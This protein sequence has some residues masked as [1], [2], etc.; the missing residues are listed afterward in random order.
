[1]ITDGGALQGDLQYKLGDEG[2]WTNEVPTAK[3][4]GTYKVYYKLE[5]ADKEAGSVEVTVSPKPATLSLNNQT[6]YVGEDLKELTFTVEGRAEGD[7][8]G[9]VTPK[10]DADKATVG[11][12]VISADLTDPNPNY[13][14]TI[15]TGI[16][17]IKEPEPEPQPEPEPKP[18]PS[19]EVS[20]I[21]LARMVSKGTNKLT[22]SWPKVQNVDGYEIRLK[23]CGAKKIQFVKTIKG[24][25]TFTYTVKGR[26]KKKTYVAYV[27][28]FVNKN[29]KKNFVK[30]SPAVHAFTTKGNKKYTN[31]K[32]VKVNK[33]T[34]T[35][36]KGKSTTIKASVTRINKRRKLINTSHGPTLRYYST[37]TKIA[38]VDNKGKI[39]AVG[40]GSCK[41]CV[42]A[43]NGVRKSVKVTVK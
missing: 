22:I 40:Q 7:S 41:I 39:T 27:R 32:A 33:D 29:G 23:A 16:Y 1:M 8:I 6:S 11:N 20:G 3:N 43:I 28:A 36:N 38:K 12:Y 19:K 14:I 34:V 18:E 9:T 25:K 13:K 17:T 21:L 30:K 10:T 35:L 15:K 31:P 2:T 26:K 42:L 24:N 37:N 4:A 5:E